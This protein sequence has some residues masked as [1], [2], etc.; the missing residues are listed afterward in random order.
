MKRETSQEQTPTGLG[1]FSA[2]DDNIS[3][4]GRERLEQGVLQKSGRSALVSVFSHVLNV[5]RLL[6]SLIFARRRRSGRCDDR[7]EFSLWGLVFERAT[8][9]L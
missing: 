8:A 2:N 5:P 4:L 3:V 9:A 1:S 7:A 6:A